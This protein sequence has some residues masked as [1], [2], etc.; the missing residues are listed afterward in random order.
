M[1]IFVCYRGSWETFDVPRDQSVGTMKQLVKDA[2]LV[3]LL[4]DAH[5][6]E[7]N[8]AG[9]AMQ[10]S[11]TLCDVGITS[12]SLIK[13]LIKSEQKPVLFVFNVVTKDMLPVLRSE[14]LMSMSVA[15]LKSIISE[16]TN[17]PV[18]IF[19]LTTSSNVQ[20]YDCN[21]LQDYGI[22][23]GAVLYLD[24]W[25]GWVEFLQGCLLGNKTTVLSHFSQQKLVIRF[26]QRVALYIASSLGHL[27]LACWLLERRVHVDE[28]VGVHP[29][30]Q[31]CHR[32]A[33]SESRKCPV[34]VAA[35]RGQ[36]L[37]LKLFITKDILALTCQDPQ[38]RDALK[39][40][41]QNRHVACVCFLAEKLCSVASF[42]NIS[43]PMRVYLRVKLWIR[44]SQ[45]RTASA[46][47]QNNLPSR[48][49][50][51]CLVDGY[52][53]SNMSS[54]LKGKE[55]KTQKAQNDSFFTEVHNIR[56]SRGDVLKTK[57]RHENTIIYKEK[58]PPI[59]QSSMSE[60]L[61]GAPLKSSIIHPILITNQT[62]S[63]PRENAVYYMTL[64]SH[65][66]EKPWAKQLK[67][68]RTLAKKHI[69][70]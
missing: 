8:Y 40:A 13:C 38:G 69:K 19:R 25:D 29:S 48:L 2:F 12:G 42:W 6:M 20:L 60:V 37:I 14:S 66:T 24:T 21:T 27:D 35:E 3:S 31:W 11:W 53:H 16:K 65:F 62:K 5:Y 36:L 45:R 58:L 28:P 46:Q 23:E 67:I 55:I 32:A 63:T 17:L 61:V 10:D 59:Q 18:S 64:A 41:I 26:Q 4:D 70:T 30:R 15:E 50:E 43:L 7:L 54:K 1:R 56:P 22:K 51:G 44:L 68:A 9:A 39:I 49:V 33:H 57:S 47:C 34:H 52:N